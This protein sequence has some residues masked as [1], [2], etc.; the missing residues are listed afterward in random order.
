MVSE[1]ESRYVDHVTPGSGKAKE[2]ASE[3]LDLL[4]KK[5][6]D[7]KQILAI[8]CDSTAVNTGINGGVVRLLDKPFKNPIYWFVCL[9]HMNELPLRHLFSSLDGPPQAQE[10]FLVLSAKHCRLATKI[11]SFVLSQLKLENYYVP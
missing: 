2:I 6:V 10:L 3:I 9:L 7:T 1:P 5:S 8:G 4:R 11:Q